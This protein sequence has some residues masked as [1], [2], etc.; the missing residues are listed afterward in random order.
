MNHLDHAMSI[1]K[2]GIPF[3]ALIKSLLSSMRL[4]ED[5][6][7]P[8]ALEK[9][10][11]MKSLGQASFRFDNK[12]E[13]WFNIPKAALSQSKEPEGLQLERLGME[14][15]T[16]DKMFVLL[17]SMIK[18]LSKNMNE[19][20][21]G[22]AKQVQKIDEKLDTTIEQVKKCDKKVFTVAQQLV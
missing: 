13:K 19:H 2:H 8:L 21:L 5:G 15:S 22:L 16:T 14:M 1:Q 12:E 3:G 9:P 11:D 18:D 4:Y 10:L 6:P 17:S 20:Y 7:N